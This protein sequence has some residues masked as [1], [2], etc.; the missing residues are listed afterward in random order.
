MGTGCDKQRRVCFRHGI[1]VDAHCDHSGEQLEG[2]FDVDHTG[3][4]APWPEAVYVDAPS[5]CDGTVL[6]P[7]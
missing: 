4:D 7:A 1:K 3:L 2:R 6:M 5:D